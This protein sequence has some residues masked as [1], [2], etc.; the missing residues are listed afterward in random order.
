[1]D[2]AAAVAAS[3][4]PRVSLLR[5][6]LHAAAALAMFCPAVFEPA[7]ASD[8]ATQV[9]PLSRRVASYDI[10]VRLDPV[11][12]LLSGRQHV[13]WRNDTSHAATELRLHLYLNA[14]KNDRT[15]FMKESGGVHRSSRMREG[16]WGYIDI[17]SMRLEDGT[18]L[19]AGAEFVRPDDG[20]ADD[21]TVLRV[22]LVPMADPVG[23][24]GGIA[25]DIEFTARLPRVFAR[26]GY[27]GTFHLVGQWFP[28]LGVL[29]EDGWNCHQFHNHSEFFADFG[30]YDVSITVPSGFVVGATG[31][32]AGEPVSSPDAVTYRFV[33]DDVHDF[34][35]T[36]DSR[37]LKVV[38][39]FRAEEQRD[40]AEERRMARAL[41]IPADSEEIRLSDVEVTLL[42]HPEHRALI[43]RHFAAAFHALRYFGYWY[44]RYPYQTLTVVD[45]AFGASGAGGMEYPTFI[46]AGASFVAPKSR[47]S[48]ESVTIHEFGHQ[49]WYGMVAS[50]EAEEAFLDE[51]F[52]SYSTGRVLQR[53]YGDNGE[54]V[55][56]AAGVPYMAAPLLEIPRRPDALTRKAAPSGAA[57][58]LMDLVWLRPFGPSDDL[59]LNAV[60]DLAPLTYMR[61]AR[62]DEVTSWRRRYLR[63]PLA[64]DLARRSWEYVDTESYGLNSYA[65]TALML[66]TLEGILGEDQMLRTMRAYFQRYRFRHPAM[67]DFIATVRETTGRDLGRFF[68]QAVFSSGVMDYAVADLSSEMPTPGRGYFGSVEPGA[69]RGEPAEPAERPRTEQDNSEGALQK[70]LIARKGEFRWPQEIELLYDGRAPV[71]RDWDGEYRWTRLLESGPKPASVRIDPDSKMD[72]DINRANNSRASESRPLAAVT[73]W[74]R[75]LRWTQHVLYFYSGLS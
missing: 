25:L 63:A 11:R 45:P 7:G 12:H 2:H 4:A 20:N 70:V 9:G 18:D 10:Q 60:R 22:P 44:G 30:S 19:L 61:G 29:Q 1:M 28:K 57:A 13:T 35:W 71:R 36:A 62:I 73:W 52:N 50:N 14:F 64:D 40:P 48:P 49:Y 58:W 33:Q 55:E 72:L 16:G 37:Y 24:G 21:E 54:T 26:T 23:P 3:S 67:R 42:I 27:K 68:E 74:C 39:W 31:A 43:D 66:S 8:A 69:Q 41:G 75:L 56:L 53:A 34:A 15:T 38:R 65:R 47:L 59:T 17:T 6:A 32:P 5:R 46:T 51:G